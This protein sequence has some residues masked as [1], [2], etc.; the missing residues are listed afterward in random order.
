MANPWERMIRAKMVFESVKVDNAT[1][2]AE[3]VAN[4]LDHPEWLDDETHVVWEIAT[5]FFPTV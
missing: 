4:D 3:N 1:T 2:L 5:E